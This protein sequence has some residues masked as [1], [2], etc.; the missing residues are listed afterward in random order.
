MSGL[1]SVVT[2]RMRPYKCSA[3]RRGLVFDLM[4][5]SKLNI[6]LKQKVL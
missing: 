4:F 5:I 3:V 1:I 2:I 6:F